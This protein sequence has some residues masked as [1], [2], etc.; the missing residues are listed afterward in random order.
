M[1]LR[2]WILLRQTCY[3]TEISKWTF[4]FFLSYFWHKIKGNVNVENCSVRTQI[5]SIRQSVS[6]SVSQ[7]VCH[8]ISLHGHLDCCSVHCSALTNNTNNS[9]TIN[10]LSLPSKRYCN[11]PVSSDVLWRILLSDNFCTSS[12]C[13]IPIVWRCF[14]DPSVFTNSTDCTD[15]FNKVFE[16]CI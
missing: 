6:Q 8:T 13:N 4:P 9:P 7:S 11:P 14:L 5:L 12:T 3:L 1:Q 10:D 2:L 16:F 15:I